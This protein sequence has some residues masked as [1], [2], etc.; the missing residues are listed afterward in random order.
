MP[1]LKSEAYESEMDTVDMGP[2]VD[3]GTRNAQAPATSA[4]KAAKKT[5]QKASGQAAAPQAQAKKLVAKNVDS[6]I[7]DILSRIDG[8]SKK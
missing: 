6:E 4:I 1:I 7:E 8:I 2:A 3:I 5:P